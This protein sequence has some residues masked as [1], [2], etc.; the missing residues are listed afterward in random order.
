MLHVVRST[1]HSQTTILR[2]AARLH[3]PGDWWEAD[4]T[5]GKGGFWKGLDEPRLKFDIDPQA[6]GVVAASSDALP[7][8]DDSL[9]SVVFDPPFLTY[10][11]AGR[12]GNGSMIM[13][14]QF[15]G[16]WRYDE[17][18]E[19]YK[20]S[21]TEISRVLRKDGV[22]IFKCQD[23]V[24]NHRLHP[25][26]SFVIEWARARGLRLLDLYVLTANHRLPAPNRRGT[27]KHARIHHSYFLLFRRAGTD[28]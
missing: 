8:A 13:A 26:H 28:G 18:E 24:H 23:I 5:Y 20:N 25:T 14:R 11:R 9:G 2:D 6:P 1:S 15:A 27:Q 12:N 16:Y 10:V 22:L 19:H 17:L 4:L 21:L 7:L 3:L